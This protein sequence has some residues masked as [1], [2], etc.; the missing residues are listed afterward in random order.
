M[1]KD[2]QKLHMILAGGTC[3]SKALVQM[4]LLAS[5]REDPFLADTVSGLCLGV[6]SGLLCGALTG[7]ALCLSLFDPQIAASDMIPQLTEWFREVTVDRYGGMDCGTILDG[8]P[9]TKALRCPGLVEEVWRKCREILEDE[10]FD[11][12]TAAENL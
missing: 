3:C 11:L 6:H 12:E 8:D 4:G 7:G 10:G 1:E 2:I 9:A 5:G